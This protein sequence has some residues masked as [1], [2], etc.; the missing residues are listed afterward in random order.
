MFRVCAWA[1]ARHT[2][3]HT[4]QLPHTY[5][6]TCDDTRH[7]DEHWQRA[8]IHDTNGCNWTM[9]PRYA[10]ARK[11]IADVSLATRREEKKKFCTPRQRFWFLLH[12]SYFNYILVFIYINR[13]V[14]NV[15]ILFPSYIIPSFSVPFEDLFLSKKEGNG[16]GIIGDDT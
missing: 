7:A 13:N 3:T 11:R 4:T 14:C 8:S 5:T 1:H 16:R 10:H 12:D 6:H 15:M 9:R 2:H